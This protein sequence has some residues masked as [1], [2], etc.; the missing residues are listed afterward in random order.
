MVYLKLVENKNGKVKPFFLSTE[1]TKR[2]RKN[3]LP[4]VNIRPPQHIEDINNYRNDIDTAFGFIERDIAKSIIDGKAFAFGPE[5][6]ISYQEIFDPFTPVT[7]KRSYY[8]RNKRKRLQS[9]VSIAASTP[10]HSSSSENEHEKEFNE[11]KFNLAN[12]TSVLPKQT[13]CTC[14]KTE[15]LKLYCDCFAAGN[16]CGEQCGCQNCSNFDVECQ[17][18]THV[19]N[20]QLVTPETK[21]I[22]AM[23]S[24]SS[25]KSSNS[26]MSTSTIDLFQDSDVSNKVFLSPP[27][28]IRRLSLV[29]S[30]KTKRRRQQAIM[31]ILRK[32]PSAFQSK[33]IKNEKVHRSGCNCKKSGCTK[34]YCECFSNG[35]G[36][37]DHCNCL[38]CKNPH[39]QKD[40]IKGEESDVNK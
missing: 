34:K 9:A 35:V 2:L 40:Q 6:E 13:S 38:T 21:R 25:L 29:D 33:I 5:R 24:V 36:C 11:N 7:V 31:K 30:D 27:A 1:Q 18:Q 20:K 10:I 32:N 37:G 17:L 15:C 4:V 19:I 12:Q 3:T 8:R 39:K 26:M 23:T 14:K 16:Y 22:K 28:T